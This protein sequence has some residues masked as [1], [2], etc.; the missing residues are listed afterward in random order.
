M[1]FFFCDFEVVVFVGEIN[2]LAGLGSKCGKA[3]DGSSGAGLQGF[4]QDGSRTSEYLKANLFGARLDGSDGRSGCNGY[5][6]L[7]VA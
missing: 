6:A 7:Q 2:L 3:Q 5:A 1:L 4:K